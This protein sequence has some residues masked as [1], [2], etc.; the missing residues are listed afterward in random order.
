MTQEM[1]RIYQE[2]EEEAVGGL[3]TGERLG[4][5]REIML[6]REALAPAVGTPAPDFDLPVLHGDGQ[7]V[8]LAELRGQAVALIFGSYT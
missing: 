5:L 2:M 3:M 4:R 7:R 1:Q 6:R 8:R